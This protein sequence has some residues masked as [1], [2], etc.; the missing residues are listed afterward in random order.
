[1]RKIDKIHLQILGIVCGT[2]ITSFLGFSHYYTGID[3]YSTLSM[4][5]GIL[6]LILI[7]I[8]PQGDENESR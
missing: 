2:F 3:S 7:F 1:M 8:E 6:T 4:I 5:V